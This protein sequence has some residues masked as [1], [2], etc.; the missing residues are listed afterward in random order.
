MTTVTV[1]R[2]STGSLAWIALDE[3]ARVLGADEAD[4]LHV[5]SRGHVAVRVFSPAAGSLRFLRNDVEKLARER[6]DWMDVRSVCRAVGSE[7]AMWREMRN[8][9][10]RK[11]KAGRNVFYY[12]PDVEAVIG[13]QA[14]TS[15][16]PDVE[17]SE[18]PRPAQPP[19]VAV[20][21]EDWLTLRAAAAL[22]GVS[23]N[24]M[25]KLLTDELVGKVRTYSPTR[26]RRYYY[27]PD[28]EAYIEARGGVVKGGERG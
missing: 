3:A 27:R 20:A 24:T 13:A 5:I 26:G 8:A 21:L 28:V 25:R 9:D 12:R 19:R 6:G 2:R 14:P 15:P 22:V 7:D 16:I 11:V 17:A 1:P 23:E 10:V 18:P 4:A